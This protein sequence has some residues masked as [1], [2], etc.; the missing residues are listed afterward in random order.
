M[1][2]KQIGLKILMSMCFLLRASATEAE[3][4]PKVVMR[5]NKTTLACLVAVL[6]KMDAQG[7]STKGMQAAVEDFGEV[8]IISF[9]QDP[10]DHDYLVDRRG[11]TWRVRRR[12]A[13][14][15]NELVSR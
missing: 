3:P 11:S 13:R 1:K 9:Y 14:V 6:H 4:V 12:D 2:K 15:L 10:I 8:V 7:R 5:A